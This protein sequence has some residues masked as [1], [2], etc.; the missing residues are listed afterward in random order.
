VPLTNT[1]VAAGESIT[2]SSAA[3]STS[4]L[5]SFVLDLTQ[6]VSPSPVVFPSSVPFGAGSS[7]SAPATPSPLIIP[8]GASAAALSSSAPIAPGP[9]AGLGLTVTHDQHTLKI[10]IG[11]SVG[12]GVALVTLV[13]A[14]VWMRWKYRTA[15]THYTVRVPD[16]T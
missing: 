6:T 12:G 10:V 3:V 7:P 14:V 8:L 13:L 5:P 9:S 15:P 4:S 1:P 16:E 2:Q 11:A